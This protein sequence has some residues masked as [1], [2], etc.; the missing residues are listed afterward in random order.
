MANP[1]G[2]MTVF[3]RAV[4]RGSFAAA[5]DDL[6]LSPSAVSKLITRLESRLGARLL[7][8]TTRRLALTADGELFF[9]RSRKILDAIEA[10][11]AEVTS[12]RRGAQGH[13]RVHVFPTFAVDHLSVALPAFLARYPRITFE[14]VVTNR[15][16]NLIDDNIDI[17]L[18]VGQLGK[19]SFVARKIADLSQIA[20]ASPAYLARHGRPI[21]PSDL[22]Q[23]SCLTLSHLPGSR[24][25]TFASGGE[26]VRVEV[27][28]PVAADS[29][30]ML[31]KLAISGA[32]VVRFGDIIV[33]N[34]VRDG[35]LV[36]LLEDWQELATF[37]LW[38]LHQAGRQRVPRVKAF[39]DFLTECFGGAP[40][41]AQPIK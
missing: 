27:S 21:H 26:T 31:L 8:R 25:W 10:A 2:E 19:S 39:V 22:E 30:H 32:G 34:A 23:H 33:A 41:R 15:E 14:F 3:V 7:I 36:P 28:G 6:A 17:A 29:A 18:Q 12:A 4:E 13:L 35:L 37:P 9:E 1:A 11:E 40:W 24:T 20:C 16:V 38:A 5:A